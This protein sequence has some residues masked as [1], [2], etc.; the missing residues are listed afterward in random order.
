MMEIAVLVFMVVLPI[1]FFAWAIRFKTVLCIFAIPPAVL[2]LTL[3][4]FMNANPVID[5]TSHQCFNVV[6]N[7]TTA[8]NFTTY[9][10]DIVCEPDTVPYPIDPIAMIVL[11]V[12]MFA[13]LFTVITVIY[14]RLSS[15]FAD[16]DEHP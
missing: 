2:L 7:S 14:R 3:V 5:Y 9:G 11:N 15:E 10:N 12:G 16:P 6:A 8:G 13:F 1:A 4:M